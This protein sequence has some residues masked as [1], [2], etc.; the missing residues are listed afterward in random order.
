LASGTLVTVGRSVWLWVRHSDD[1]ALLRCDPWDSPQGPAVKLTRPFREVHTTAGAMPLTRDDYELAAG[2]GAADLL[3]LDRWTA[4]LWRIDATN[5]AA[6]V[7][8]T[9]VALPQVISPPAADARD[10]TITFFAGESEAMEPRVE[11]RV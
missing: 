10:G 9:L 8:Q 4:A 11:E 2:A 3:L 5:G 6:G 1:S 7:M